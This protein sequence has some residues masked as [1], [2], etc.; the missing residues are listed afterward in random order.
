MMKW[1]P[2]SADQFKVLLGNISVD[3]FLSNLASK[4]DRNWV[5]NGSVKIL[6]FDGITFT[7]YVDSSS[8]S[9]A[10]QILLP[11]GLKFKIRLQ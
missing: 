11:G 3:E 6:D 8:N 1:S 2:N 7:S 4:L 5:Q 9:P 10:I